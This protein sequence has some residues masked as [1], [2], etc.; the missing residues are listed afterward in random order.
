MLA[1]MSSSP[2]ML[3]SLVKSIIDVAR[4]GLSEHKRRKRLQQQSVAKN[5]GVPQSAIFR[6]TLAPLGDSSV[7]GG[8]VSAER[9]DGTRSEFTRYLVYLHERDYSPLVMLVGDDPFH[10]A[11]SD[12]DVFFEK[13][14]MFMGAN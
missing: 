9:V 1:T 4:H 7:W 5:L 2:S 10:T 12:I 3:E 13:W 6:L 11:G 14:E 8:E